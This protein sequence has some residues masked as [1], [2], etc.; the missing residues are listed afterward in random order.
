LIPEGCIIYIKSGMQQCGNDYSKKIMISPGDI[1]Q[2]PMS[3]DDE[4]SNSN[5]RI[6]ADNNPQ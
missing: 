3:N 1:G 6:A 4:I 2:R 5:L